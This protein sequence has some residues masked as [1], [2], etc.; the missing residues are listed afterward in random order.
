MTLADGL[1]SLAKELAA[2]VESSEPKNRRA[3]STAYYALFHLLV[4]EACRE[5]A[6]QNLRLQERLSR[7]FVHKTMR[8]VCESI[9]TGRNPHKFHD[10]L[11]PVPAPQD[12]VIVSRNFSQ[13]QEARE[14]ADY[15]IGFFHDHITAQ[16]HVEEAVIAFKA[17][18]SIRDQQYA[19]VFLLALLFSR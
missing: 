8:V 15:D 19:R 2:D 17:W 6:S 10:G 7:H 4:G 3:I 14:K 5:I 18:Q 13:L 1:L 9:A 11:L 16:L 12:L